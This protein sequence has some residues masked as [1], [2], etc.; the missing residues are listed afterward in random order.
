MAASRIFVSH[1]HADTPF[2]REFVNGL[3]GHGFDVWYD[4]HNLGWG[5][6]RATIER[7]MPL[8]QHFVAI[9]SPTA[10]ASE[11]VNTEIDAA[12]EL[13]QEGTL[14]SFTFVVAERCTVPLLLR[15]WKRIE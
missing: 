15:R 14:R 2:C 3:R 13:L 9:L 6:L 12:L 11:W 5:A 4:E 10:V 1:S 7:E 8:C